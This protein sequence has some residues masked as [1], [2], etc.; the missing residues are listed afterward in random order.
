MNKKS[1][2]GYL[3]ALVLLTTVLVFSTMSIGQERS[4]EA[5]YTAALSGNVYTYTV[6]VRNTS[7]TAGMAIYSILFGQQF[8]VPITPPLPFQN[9][10]VKTVPA[11]WQGTTSGGTSYQGYSLSF[12]SN[13]AGSVEGS[14]YILPGQSATFVFTS[15]TPPPGDVKFGVDYYYNSGWGGR[16]VAGTAKLISQASGTAAA[17]YHAFR[18]NDQWIYVLTVTN[19]SQAANFSVYAILF[20]VHYN[21][22]MTP[23]LPFQS[24]VIKSLPSAWQGSTAGGGSYQGY[25]FSFSPGG[26]GPDPA[27]NHIPAG[28]SAIFVFTSPTPPPA[29]VKFGVNF[30]NGAGQWGFPFNGEATYVQDGAKVP[31]PPRPKMIKR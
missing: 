21:A 7:P 28:G 19:T 4:A 14:H 31:V 10:V 25:S 13:W 12:S 15:S 6:T 24:P 20:G 1:L 22:P 17:N 2:K 8:N 5:T 11:G 9:V 26:A 16:S 18:M 27:A 3:P 29:G 23:P 30:Y